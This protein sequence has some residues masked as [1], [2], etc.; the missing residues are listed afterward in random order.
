MIAAARMLTQ[1]A[2]TTAFKEYTVL[3]QSRKF[4]YKAMTA[5]RLLRVLL[6]AL[7]ALSYGCSEVSYCVQCAVGHLDVMSK[8][9]PIEEVL[10]DPAT[11]DAERAKLTKLLDIRDFAVDELGLPDNDSYRLYADIEQPYVVWNVVATPEFSMTPKQWCYPVV[12]CVSYRGYFDAQDANTM[13]DELTSEGYDVDVYG[14]KAYS[15]LNWFDDPVLSTFIDGTD[16]QLAALIFHELSHQVVYAP[17]DCAFNEAFAKTV[18]ME[19]LRRWLHSRSDD[20]Q[21]HQYLKLE[22]LGQQFVDTLQQTRQQLVQLYQQPLQ[23][24]A[25][26][27]AKQQLMAQLEAELRNLQQR[28]PDPAAIDSWLERGLNNA[29]LASVA[30]YHDQVPA[31]QALLQEKNGD[32]PAFF[33]EVERLAQLPAEERTAKLKSYGEYQAQACVEMTE[34]EQ[35]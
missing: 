19:G 2:R 25:K 34:M 30:T 28:W 14:V 9:R 3:K 27:A 32:L 23:E 15:T 7:L 21:W 29:R 22:E 16:R 24:D 31:F 13:G 5:R 1:R 20:K 11:S 4:R 10:E 8:V 33:V 6:L 12:G 17:G 18:E 26:R 35:E